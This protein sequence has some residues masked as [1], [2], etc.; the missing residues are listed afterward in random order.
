MSVTSPDLLE[1]TAYMKQAIET[2]CQNLQRPFGALLLDH[3]EGEVL[4]TAVNRAYRNPVAH[5]ELEV[6]QKVVAKQG[7]DVRWGDCTMYV[8][9][10][11]C[12]M[13]ISGILWAGIPRVVYGSSLVTLHDLGYR[14]IRLRAAEVVEKAG[15]SLVGTE[16][17]GGVMEEECDA[18]FAA[19][20]KLDRKSKG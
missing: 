16:L 20:I 5:A 8:T 18:L 10:E 7:G 15:P 6:I 1:H 19:A 2:A 12:S 9:A 13:C 14:Q 17:I 11:P 3:R 4:A